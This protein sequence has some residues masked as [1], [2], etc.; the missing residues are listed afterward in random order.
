M[1][2]PDV[3]A[4]T[5]HVLVHYPHTS[6][7]QTLNDME[8]FHVAEA[9][10]E[11][12]RALLAYTAAIKCGLV[13]LQQLAKHELERFG[14]EMNIFDVVEAVQ[15]EFSKIRCNDLWCYG[16]LR[17]RSKLHLMKTTQCL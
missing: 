1:D 4:S 16:F 14:T 17:A 3:D 11:F 13:G 12:K 6:L 15:D 9:N 2:L 7:Y 5:G 8:T 10:I